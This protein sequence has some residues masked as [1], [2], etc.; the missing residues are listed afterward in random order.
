MVC[1]VNVDSINSTMLVSLPRPTSLTNLI[2]PSSQVATL[3]QIEEDDDDLDLENTS[4]NV[5]DVY[6]T[7]FPKDH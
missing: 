2:P 6:E 1:A 4:L 3:V 7:F 5:Q